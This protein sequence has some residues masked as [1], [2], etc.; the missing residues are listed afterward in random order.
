MRSSAP[1]VV[2]GWAL[3][4]SWTG[5]PS[6]ARQEDLSDRRP[7]FTTGVE[8]VTVNVAVLDSD[9]RPVLGLTAKDF[10][11][12]EDGVEAEVPL[13]LAPG[14][15]PL[16][17]AFVLD[18]SGS[19]GQTAPY[20]Q[21]VEI[22][23]LEALSPDDCVF[24]LPFSDRIGPGVWGRPHQ[25]ALSSFI[26]HLVPFGGTALFEAMLQGLSALR[27]ASPTAHPGAPWVFRLAPDGQTG[28]AS[29]APS[30]SATTVSAGPSAEGTEAPCGA[31][32]RSGSS[33]GRRHAMVVLT[34]GLDNRSFATH[35]ETLTAIRQAGVPV[36]AVGAGAAA[37]AMHFDDGLEMRRL[38]E[39]WR[40]FAEVSGGKFIKG[41]GSHRKLEEAYDEV[42][43][44]LRASYLIGFLPPPPRRAETRLA[45]AMSWC[46]TT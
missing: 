31:R 18:I 27:A 22:A 11:V 46:G 14:D 23:F 30:D 37:S 33:A 20:A 44:L 25:P 42:L 12:I 3:I 38:E 1:F 17:I 41:N 40:E 21:A 7:V 34:D 4:A 2:L 24:V 16:D 6:G 5:T 45:T 15:T 36:I 9:G 8:M 13:V 19:I 43:D 26:R 32:V 35:E 39:Q 10:V 29:A 28:V